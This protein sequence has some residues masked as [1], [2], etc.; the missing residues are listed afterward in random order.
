MPRTAKPAQKSGRLRL[1]PARSPITREFALD[2]RY[3]LI[4]KLEGA[5]SG[6]VVEGVE[7]VRIRHSE[8]FGFRTGKAPPP[9]R[10]EVSLTFD[11][12]MPLS[13][14]YR[15]LQRAWPRLV[16]QGAVDASRPLGR[17]SL[18]LIE[19][20]CVDMPSATWAERFAAWNSKNPRW[21]MSSRQ[22]FIAAFHA[23]ERSLIGE[24]YA[25]AYWYDENARLTVP[26]LH[27]KA[28]RGDAAARRELERRRRD[29]INSLNRM[30]HSQQEDSSR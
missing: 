3:A 27:A 1:D 22:A 4:A 15:A 12:R 9:L 28:E 18:V 5:V 19:H 7:A 29:G 16:S 30:T 24:P 25:L 20:V 10:H 17:R 23:G 26:Q 21:R 13:S 2:R 6:S 11:Y 8:Q 14:V